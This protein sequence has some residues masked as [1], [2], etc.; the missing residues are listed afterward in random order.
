[1]TKMLPSLLT[2][3]RSAL[4]MS[5]AFVRFITDECP[6]WKRRILTNRSS[7]DALIAFHPVNAGLRVT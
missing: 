6:K 1:V 7:I 4:R 3:R 2:R 5:G